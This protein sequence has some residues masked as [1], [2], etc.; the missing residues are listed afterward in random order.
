MRVGV[1]YR[2]QVNARATQRV[3]TFNWPVAWHVLWYV[4]PTSPQRGAPQLDF[5]TE[6]ERASSDRLTYWITV[7][8]LTAQPVDYELRYAVLN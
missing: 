5:N 4:A 1:Q 3:F 2:G 8:N 6:V 7:R